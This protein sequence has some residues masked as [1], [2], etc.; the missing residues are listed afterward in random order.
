MVLKFSIN[1]IQLHLSST[2][3]RGRLN[4]APDAKMGQN[5]MEA[6]IHVKH[7]QFCRKE[8]K[9]LVD[10]NEDSM[11]CGYEFNKDAC[12]VKIC[13]RLICFNYYS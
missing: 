8:V 11:I 4:E 2:H 6:K 13:E 7:N 1:E 10:F 5:L 9:R 12:Q 3:F